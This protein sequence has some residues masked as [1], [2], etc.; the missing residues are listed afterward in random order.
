[1]T[2]KS[3]SA[4]SATD[5]AKTFGGLVDRVREARVT[6]VIE[7]GGTPVAQIGPVASS[8]CT[9][10]E[11]VDMLRT[12]ERASEEYLRRVEAGVKAANKPAVPRD[13]WTS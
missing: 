11:L 4:I 1:M 6:Y 13:P 3:R 5:A 10:R 9:V 8:R 2:R 7:R 12:R